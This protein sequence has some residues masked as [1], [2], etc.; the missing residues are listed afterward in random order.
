MDTT[1]IQRYARQLYE[2][3]GAKAIPEAAQKAIKFERSEDTEQAQIWRKIEAA[4]LL[5]HG[6]RHS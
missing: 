6:P 5:I 1:Q 2:A 3:Q 4:L